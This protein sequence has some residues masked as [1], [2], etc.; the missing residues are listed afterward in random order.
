MHKADPQNRTAWQEFNAGIIEE[1]PLQI[2]IIPF[3]LV[4]GILGVESGLSPVQTICLSVILFGGASQIVF[5]QLVASG[6]PFG[7]I[8]AS[9]TTINLRHTLYGLSMAVY[10]RE[11]PLSWRLGLAYLLTDE[12]YAVSVRR[13]SQQSPSPY[14]HFHLLGTGLT[15]HLFWQASTISG[16]VIGQTL[17]DTLSL[18]FVIPLTFIAILAPVVKRPA[19]MVAACCATAVVFASYHLPW[20]LWLILAALAGIVGGLATERLAEQRGGQHN[21]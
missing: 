4:F 6:T 15:L 20:N 16:V 9:V 10:L 5:A 18:G 19:E 8:L 12:A 3:G 13:F 2:G 7:I 14:M 1:L 11:L 21:E 17:P